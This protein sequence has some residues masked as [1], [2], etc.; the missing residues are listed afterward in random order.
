M[1][2]NACSTDQASVVLTCNNTTP[3][4]CRP[5]V[6]GRPY[7]RPVSDDTPTIEIPADLIGLQHAWAEA[8][9][10]VHDRIAEIERHEAEYLAEHGHRPPLPTTPDD[11][12][13]ADDQLAKLR[14]IRSEAKSAVRARVVDLAGSPDRYWAVRAALL[15]AAAEPV[16]V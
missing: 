15:A 10:A 11:P 6:G 14:T 12:G 8:D 2:P 1:M 3:T 5:A 7:D 16:A 4:G 13:R 9:R